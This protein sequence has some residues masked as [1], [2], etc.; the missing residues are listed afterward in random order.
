MELKPLNYA[1]IGVGFVTIMGAILFLRGTPLM[2]LLIVVGVIVSSVPF[3]IDFLKVQKVRKAKESK[4]LEFMRD[5]VENVRT[6]T[7]ISR[8]IIN[9]RKRDYGDLTSHIDKLANQLSIGSPIPLH[10]KSSI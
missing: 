6:G 3:L 8:G 1:G 4:F 5:L 10:S 7:P 9:L 2:T